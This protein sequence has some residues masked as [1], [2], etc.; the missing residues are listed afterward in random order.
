MHCYCIKFIIFGALIEKN[1]LRKGDL[2]IGILIIICL[3]AC[4]NRKSTKVTA[5][6]DVVVGFYNLE[7]LFDTI[8]TPDVRDEE[9]TP[10]GRKQWNTERYMQKQNQLAQIIA[11]IGKAEKI[12]G[13]AVMGLCEVENLQVIEELVDNSFLKPFNYQ[14]VH[15]DSP[16]KRGIDVAL[17]YKADQFKVDSYNAIPLFIYD[18]ESGDRIHTRDQLLVSGKLLGEQVHFIVNH[19]PSRYGGEERS[20]P[21]RKS[22]AELSRS[23]IDSLQAINPDANIILMGDLNDDPHNVSVKDVLRAVAKDELSA[24]DLYNTLVEKHRNG[25]GTLC[26]RGEWN[27]FDQINIS[28]SLLKEGN[29]LTY[30]ETFILEHPGLKVKEGDYAGYPFRTYVGNRYD[31]GYSDH[32]PVYM[33]INKN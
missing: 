17:I 30:K 26:Y 20:R 2:F 15:Q 3:S 5:P 28:Q 23:I 19:W 22:A 11:S 6:K 12:D 16:D 8:N 13:A 33:L 25:E 4:N 18:Q 7:N 32:L 21:M 27:M 31:G 29:A 9:F 1:M 10:N 14:I 24:D